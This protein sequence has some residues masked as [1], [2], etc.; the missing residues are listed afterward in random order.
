M[1]SGLELA[2]LTVTSFLYR[3]WSKLNKGFKSY[4]IIAVTILMII[5]SAGIYGFL[6]SAYSSTSD[7]LSQ[8]DGQIVLLE[9][10]KENLNSSIV[11]IKEIIDTKSKRINILTSLR[12]TQE[13][14][15]D[16]LYKKLMITGV[17]KTEQI[18]KNAD[19][20]IEKTNHQID[21]LSRVNQNITNS[22]G[23]IDVKILELQSS[24]IKGEIGPLKY[25][26]ILTG[27]NIDT[28]VNFFILLLIF[29]CD[30]LAVC[31]VIATNKVLLEKE[32]IKVEEKKN[33]FY[34]TVYKR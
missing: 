31:L 28:V 4:L 17:R 18:I 32:E 13:S 25:I 19:F 15:I 29:V 21:S 23:K 24:N 10:K 6:S 26:A 34:R 9:K 3:Y 2:K 7:Q 12:T 30:P 1:V 27:Q 11:R 14:R 33:W 22:I 5:T 8:V 16:T 20:E